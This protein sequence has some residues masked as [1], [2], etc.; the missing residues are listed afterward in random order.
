MRVSHVFTSRNAYFK[1]MVCLLIL[2]AIILI[3]EINVGTGFV[4]VM[5]YYGKEVL[6]PIRVKREVKIPIA[7]VVVVQDNSNKE[8]YQQA[9]DT[10]SCYATHHHYPY[11]F[12]IV[13]DNSTLGRICP[14]KDFMF[15]RH[16]VVAHMMSLWDEQWLLFIDADMAI[17]NPNHLIEEYV[18]SD[19]DV[20]IVFYNRIFN[21]EVMA[22]SYL[23]RNSNYSYN[24]LLHW[25]NYEFKLPQSFHGTDNGAIHSAIISYELPAK[26]VARKNCEKFWSSA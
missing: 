6:I 25:S 14:Q 20:H 5:N 21:H 13:A 23:T 8:Q 7:I 4:T 1:F 19:P 10:V 12:V 11:H 18:P 17:I 2:L 3:E 16:C 24:F 15:Q 9:Q 22:G 26:D